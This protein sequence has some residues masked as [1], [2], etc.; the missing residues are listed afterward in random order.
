MK[1]DETKEPTSALAS[2]LPPL[3]TYR[4]G[5]STVDIAL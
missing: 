3:T 2:P 4:V 5:M 1:V